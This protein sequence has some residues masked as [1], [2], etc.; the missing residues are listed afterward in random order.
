MLLKF[1]VEN[2]LSFDK[3][4]GLDMFP[5]PQRKIFPSH[6]Y[7]KDP[8][9]TLKMCAIYGPNGSGKSNLVKA[10]DFLRNFVVKDN[11]LQEV[12]LSDYHFKL[13]KNP[14]GPCRLTILFGVDGKYFEYKTSI[15]E[16]LGEELQEIDPKNGQRY[17]LYRRDD[18]ELLCTW[19]RDKQTARDVLHKN[20]LVSVPALQRRFPLFKEEFAAVDELGTWFALKLKIL[21]RHN[22]ISDVNLQLTQDEGLMRFCRKLV[23]GA[24]LGLGNL[25]VKISPVEE[26]LHRQKDPAILADL[27]LDNLKRMSKQKNMP[28]VFSM[29]VHKNDRNLVNLVCG[30]D[31]E[32]KIYEMVF[33][34]EGRHGE[35]FEMPVMAQ[36]DGTVRMLTLIPVLWDLCSRDEVW[37][38]DEIESGIHPELAR[39]VVR[40]C[41]EGSG[42]GQLLFTT[43][44]EQLMDQQELLRPDEIVLL[45]KQE[46]A[47]HLKSLNDFIIQDEMDLEQGYRQGRF[48][49]RPELGTDW[50][51]RA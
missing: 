46:G 29:S 16:K 36:S 7:S 44:L 42:R 32:F 25:S 28:V 1:S 18:D 45:N 6:I 17:L 9:P 40:L 22:F 34:Q 23:S 20:P 12:S 11:F 43:H 37:L 13:R 10:F 50:R 2:F 21:H 3:E 5:N 30:Q 26:W 24:D 48:G 35:L 38:I 33:D 49:F 14:E 15:G 31:G 41:G 4:V 47:T 19:L 8:I 51:F 27:N 39:A